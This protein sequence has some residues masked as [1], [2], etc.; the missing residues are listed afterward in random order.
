[1]QFGLDPGDWQLDRA[2]IRK[3]LPDE[4]KRLAFWAT[5]TL[6]VRLDDF[7][8][9]TDMLDRAH[10]L[11]AAK[12]MMDFQLD[13][14]RVVYESALEDAIDDARRRAEVVARELNVTLGPPLGCEELS[15]APMPEDT[16][17]IPSSDDLFERRHLGDVIPDPSEFTTVNP[18]PIEIRARVRARYAIIR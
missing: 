16:H 1:R 13:E 7:T 12:I 11:K 14:P 8:A 17:P 10:S 9:A 15:D 6:R 2:M 5:I 4:P 18:E 3:P